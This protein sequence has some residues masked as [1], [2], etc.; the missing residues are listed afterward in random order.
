MTNEVPKNLKTYVVLDDGETYAEID[1][2]TIVMVTE[3]GQKLME[4]MDGIKSLGDYEPD[5]LYRWMHLS[6]M[7]DTLFDR[8]RHYKEHKEAA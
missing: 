4:D 2:C 6:E 1:G 8:L 5:G 7:L 3:E